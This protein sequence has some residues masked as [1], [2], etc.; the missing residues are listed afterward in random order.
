MVK[1]FMDY[2]FDSFGWTNG[3][4]SPAETFKSTYEL[5]ANVEGCGISNATKV[6]LMELHYFNG[7]A[8]ATI[9]LLPGYT[10]SKSALYIGNEMFPKV[11]GVNTID[12][13]NYPYKH[14][15]S[16]ASSDSFTVN[17]LSG[18]IY[19]I[20]YVLLDPEAN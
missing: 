2:G 4:L 15:L 8:T 19:I 7:T 6:G 13:A 12:P 3:A 9:T 17:G 11:E 10:M 14:D 20:G 18:N 5:F 1:C 16:S